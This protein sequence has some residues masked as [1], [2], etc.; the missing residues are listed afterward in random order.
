MDKLYYSY[1]QLHKTLQ[2]LA[3]KIKTSGESFDCIVA[4]ASGGLIPA[5][6]LKNYLNLPIYVVN[7]SYYDQND[8]HSDTST[9]IQWLANQEISGKKILLVDEIDDTRTTLAYCADK[10]LQDKPAKLAVAV[11]HNKQV[12]KKASLPSGVTYFVGEEIPGKWVV[13]PWEETDIDEH[14]KHIN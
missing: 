4:I 10:L 9:V 5:R 3:D 14:D 8:V 6:I 11:M 12:T 7:V 2:N 1:N 13:Y